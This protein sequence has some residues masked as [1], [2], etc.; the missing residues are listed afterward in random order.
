M[1][2]FHA[3]FDRDRLM[4]LPRDHAAKLVHQMLEPVNN[5]PPHEQ[6]GAISLLF[7]T[8]VQRF[9]IDPEEAHAIGLKMLRP[10]PFHRKGNA[11]IEALEAYAGMQHKGH[12]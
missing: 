2:Q 12:L 9:G 8:F 7:A 6:V 10:E 11:Q 4:M 3:P 5:L 1:S